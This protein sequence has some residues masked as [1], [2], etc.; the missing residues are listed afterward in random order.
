MCTFQFSSRGLALFVA[1]MAGCV[2]SIDYLDKHKI[3]LSMLSGTG[4]AFRA[5]LERAK[6]FTIPAH[7]DL[8]LMDCF[9]HIG[10]HIT[11]HRVHDNYVTYC[12]MATLE[13]Y[14]QSDVT[15]D[16]VNYSMRL[17]DDRIHVGALGTYPILRNKVDDSVVITVFPDTSVSLSVFGVMDHLSHIVKI[18]VTTQSLGFNEYSRLSQQVA[19]T[20]EQMR[21]AR[22]TLHNTQRDEMRALRVKHDEQTAHLHKLSSESLAYANDQMCQY[23][24]T[25]DIVAI[26]QLRL[27][28]TTL[29]HLDTLVDINCDSKRPRLK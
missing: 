10:T 14:D 7:S 25:L 17:F 12:D 26:R 3:K 15:V 9:T 23:E 21:L 24:D 29:H 2:S 18:L 4:V 28:C 19:S 13:V 22:N 20:V 16:N 5:A 8:M 6:P 1:T 11:S 27:A